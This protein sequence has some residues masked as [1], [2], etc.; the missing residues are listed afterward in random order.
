MKY[1][2][3]CYFPVRL[4]LFCFDVEC[5]RCFSIRV[6]VVPGKKELVGE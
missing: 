5:S 6:D 2:V 1:C 3:V 4:S